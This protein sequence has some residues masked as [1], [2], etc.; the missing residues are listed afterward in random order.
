MSSGNAGSRRSV[1]E[2]KKMNQGNQDWLAHL[3]KAH[4]EHFTGASVLE[5]GSLEWNGS[6]RGFFKEARKYVG[7]DLLDGPG[8]D[9]VRPAGET[10]FAPGS[11]DT[12][13]CLSLFEHDP[14]WKASFEHNL[15]WLREGGLAFVCWGAEGNLRHPPEPWA[16]V[17]VAEFMDAVRHW[18]VEIVDSF[19]ECERF[20]PDCPGCYDVVLRKKSKIEKPL[21]DVCVVAY[22]SEEDLPELQDDL[23][24]MSRHPIR[25]HLFDNIGNPKTLTIAWN[26]LARQGTAP[27]LA[28]LNT[29][30]RISPGWDEPL[31]QALESVPTDVGVALPMPVGHDWALRSGMGEEFP[32]ESVCPTPPREAMC[33]IAEAAKG[34]TGAYSFGAA[35]NAAFYAVLMK[36]SMFEELKGFDERFRFYGQDHDFQRRVLARYGK[37]SI[38]VHRSV[39]WHRVSGSTMKASEHGEVDFHNELVHLGRVTDATITGKIPWWDRLSDEAREAVRNDPVYGRMPRPT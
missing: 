23:T 20:T 2:D 4:P 5:I 22:R 37:Y 8:V 17:P 26:D 25:L 38:R 19:F 13:V 15:Q 29:D 39:V 12:L 18:P 6:V 16:Q 35:C 10:V 28:F 32:R 3:K 30:I 27:Y 34:D 11:F 24:L 31:V 33:R 36:R 7:V 14:G 21:I 1:P 9:I